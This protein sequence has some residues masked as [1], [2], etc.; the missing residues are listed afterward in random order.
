VGER[1]IERERHTQVGGRNREGQKKK[2]EEEEKEEEED[3]EEEELE[4]EE[5]EEE[6]E[7]EEE[8]EEEQEEEKQVSFPS[9]IWVQ[10]ENALGS[11]SQDNAVHWRHMVRN[12][13]GTVYKENRSTPRRGS[14]Q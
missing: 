10:R 13:H 4:E 2:E 8:E 11:C 7:E 9:Q 6:A 14:R 3:E 1:E 5:E 12:R